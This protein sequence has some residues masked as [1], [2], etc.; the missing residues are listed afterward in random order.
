MRDFFVD[1]FKG[2]LCLFLLEMGLVAG[3]R[4]GAFRQMGPAL[5][6]FGLYMPLV[7]AGLGIAAAWLVGFGP[8]SATLLAVL[9]ASASY[10]V[11]PAAM[12]LAVPQADPAYYVTLSLAVTFPF[13]IALGIPLYHAAAL[14]LLGD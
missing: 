2:I 6:G 3:R 12:R 14:R 8:G 5:I 4:F 11:V 13:N 1:P 9:C 10:I 7:G